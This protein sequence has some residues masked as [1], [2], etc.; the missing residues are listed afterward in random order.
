MDQQNE[1]AGSQYQTNSFN[2]NGSGGFIGGGLSNLAINY[3]SP[4]DIWWNRGP[5]YYDMQ[6]SYV[7]SNGID[8]ESS[9][10][11]TIRVH[12][13]IGLAY[14]DGDND[15]LFY[16]IS[17]TRFGNPPLLVA[18]MTA[19]PFAYQNL[20]VNNEEV[21]NLVRTTT[22]LDF[23]PQEGARIEDLRDHLPM[24]NG[25]APRYASTPPPYNWAAW[26]GG[27]DCTGTL[28]PQEELLLRDYGKVFFYEVDVFEGAAFVGTYYL[29]PDIQTL[30]DG[31]V[32]KWEKVPDA[33]GTTHLQGNF[34]PIGNFPLYYYTDTANPTT[35]TK[36]DPNNGGSGDFCNSY[37]VVFDA[38]NLYKHTITGGSVPKTI[39]MDFLQSNTTFWWHSALTLTVQ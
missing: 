18:D 8:E 20:Y 1:E 9:S 25:T 12:A 26:A 19:N 4:W 29:H 32:S 14:F 34:P 30:Y 17:P 23:L 27:F 39:T 21:G 38:R 37:E 6:P 3:Y 22:S 36:Y 10:P 11:Y 5:E 7:I 24:P 13:W 28:T 2:D 33:S 15:G 31:S 35:A 16:D